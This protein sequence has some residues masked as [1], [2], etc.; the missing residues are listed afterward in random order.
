MTGMKPIEPG[1]ALQMLQDVERIADPK[2][3]VWPDWAVSPRG[4]AFCDNDLT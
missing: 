3:G 1:Q 4:L 2:A